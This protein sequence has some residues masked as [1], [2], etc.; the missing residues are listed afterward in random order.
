VHSSGKTNSGKKGET[1]NSNLN[2]IRGKIVNK[3]NNGKLIIPQ[4]KKELKEL[5]RF[6]DEDYVTAPLTQRR[7][8]IN[9]K[10]YL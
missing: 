1:S 3:T 2:R 4:D 6:L 9:S 10:K 8:L 5:F 7:C